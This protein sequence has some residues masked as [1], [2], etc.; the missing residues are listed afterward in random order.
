MTARPPELDP[1]VIIEDDDDEW[2][3]PTPPG[4]VPPAVPPKSATSTAARA[5]KTAAYKTVAPGQHFPFPSSDDG[6][7][8]NSMNDSARSRERG[9]SR[10]VP[11]LRSI[12]ARDGGRTQS[13]GVKGV[14]TD[15][16]DS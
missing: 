8:L 15:T 5:T 1:D 10:P 4:E 6:D 14:Y 9:E 13:G 11:H 12:R 16:D 3:D 2:V 7:E